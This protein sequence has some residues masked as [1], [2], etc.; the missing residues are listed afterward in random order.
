MTKK[1]YARL[2]R[3]SK[4]KD[5]R[6]EAASQIKGNAVYDD[7]QEVYTNCAKTLIGYNEALS[8][9]CEPTLV[10]HMDDSQ[11][12][13]IG[14]LT[15]SI[16]NDIDVFVKDLVTINKPFKDKTGGETNVENFVETIGVI[17]QFAEF[18]GR[19]KGTLDPTFA[20]L[21]SEISIVVDSL[22]SVQVENLANPNVISDVEV[23]QVTQ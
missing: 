12:Q 13:K 3:D 5:A 14:L 6:T 1:S 7:I 18:I 17:D 10:P 4:M 9:I 23:K 16:K 19:C 8:V 2:E 22:P 21:A 20:S 11:K 15:Q